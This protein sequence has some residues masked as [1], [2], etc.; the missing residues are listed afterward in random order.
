M[1]PSYRQ[2]DLYRLVTLFPKG[3]IKDAQWTP[4]RFL[5]S[6]VLDQMCWGQEQA[7]LVE[8]LPLRNRSQHHTL[9]HSGPPNP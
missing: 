5:C 2:P 9:W 1:S 4:Q 7:S 8:Q 6:E 3:T